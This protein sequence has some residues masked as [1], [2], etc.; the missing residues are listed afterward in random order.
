LQNLI[1]HV[2][3]ATLIVNAFATRSHIHLLFSLLSCIG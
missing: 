1:I 2:I 3:L